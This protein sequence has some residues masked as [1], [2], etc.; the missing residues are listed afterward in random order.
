MSEEKK[1]RTRRE[2]APGAEQAAPNGE[3]PPTDAAPE[4]A[5]LPSAVRFQ[6]EFGFLCEET[7]NRYHWQ[8]GQVLANPEL[9]AIA[10][11][12]HAPVETL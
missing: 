5:P 11:G 9:I 12:R 6:R 1:P 7:G 10:I 4:P 8:E 2:A 3:V